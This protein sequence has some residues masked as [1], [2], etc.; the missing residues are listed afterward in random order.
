MSLTKNFLGAP[1]TNNAANALSMQEPVKL[2][3]PGQNPEKQTN[4]L[5]IIMMVVMMGVMLGMV[6][7]M[8]MS[9]GG[10]RNPM[11]L[12][13][14]IMMMMSMGMMMFS[15]GSGTSGELSTVRSD[16]VKELALARRDVHEAE[17]KLFRFQQA[18][19]PPPDMIIHYIGEE[20]P[21]E[22]DIIP[23]WSLTEEDPGGFDDKDGKFEYLDTSFVPYQAPR[24]G[25]S[26]VKAYPGF[27]MPEL[28]VQENNEPATTSTLRRF[29][30]THRSVAKVP[31]GISYSPDHLPSGGVGYT[32][33]QDILYEMM[34]Q[35]I[36]SLAYGH[37]P[38]I[39]RLAV[40]TTPERAP[41]WEWVKWLPHFQ[42]PLR[43]TKTG[44]GIMLYTNLPDYLE[45][46]K[47]LRGY[48]TEEGEAHTVVFVDMPHKEVSKPALPGRTHT[49]AVFA[50]G[51][52]YIATDKDNRYE[53]S[54]KGLMILPKSQSEMDVSRMSRAAAEF[55][56]MKMSQYTTLTRA[57]DEGVAVK[58]SSGAAH[59]KITWLDSLQITDM[60]SFDPRE[61]WQKNLYSSN[62][63]TPLGNKWD[64]ATNTYDES[65]LFTLDLGQRG[66]VNGDG[67][68]GNGGGDTG[69]GKSELL[70]VLVMG[71]MVNY[72]PHTAAFILMDFKGGS[73][74][75]GYDELP[76]VIANI[77]NLEGQSDMVD[78][79]YLVIDGLIQSRQEI[80][81]TYGAKDVIEYRKM[82]RQGKIPDSA[83]DL[84]DVFVIEDEYSEFLE[85]HPDFAQLFD[86]IGRVGR[87]LGIHEL[88]FTQDMNSQLLGTLG[89]QL[90][91]SIALKVNNAASRD[92]IGSGAATTDL[93]DPG[94][95]FIRIRSTEEVHRIKGFFSEAPYIPKEA[96]AE[97][98]VVIEDG[99]V[100]F[101]EKNVIEYRALERGVIDEEV[102]DVV[103][104]DETTAAEQSSDDLPNQHDVL[105]DRLRQFQDI[106]APKLWTTPLKVPF[107]YADSGVPASEVA[108]VLKVSIGEL[109]D[110]YHHRR[111]PHVVPLKG[112][113]HSMILVGAPESGKSM[114][115]NSIVSSLSLQYGPDVVQVIILD[116]TGKGVSRLVDSYPHVIASGN[117]AK[118]D[119][120][121]RFTG[122]LERIMAIRQARKADWDCS[123]MEEYFAEVKKRGL[124]NDDPYG[125]IVF[126]V[127]GMD[128]AMSNDI[129][130]TALSKQM[131]PKFLKWIQ[132]GE[133]VGVHLIFTTSNLNHK[134]SSLNIGILALAGA[135][136]EVSYSSAM[137]SGGVART[138]LKKAIQSIPKGQPGRYVDTSGLHGRFRF[139]VQDPFEPT[140]YDAKSGEPVFTYD[141]SHDARVTEL[142]A[143]VT[144]NSD[145]RRII[146]PLES[147]SKDMSY[148]YLMDRYWSHRHQGA[149]DID[150]P[151]GL[152]VSDLSFVT[153]PARE[154]LFVAGDKGVGKSSVLRTVMNAV[155]QQ[156]SSEPKERQP[157]FMI[158]DGSGDW[159]NE[160][161]VMEK[162]GRLAGYVSTP[163]E[164]KEMFDAIAH[165]MRAHMPDMETLTSEQ[166]ENRTWYS[167]RDI[168]VIIDGFQKFKG[169]YLSKPTDELEKALLECGRNDLGFQFFISD[170]TD[171]AISLFQGKNLVQSLTL[172]GLNTL[173][174]SSA[175]KQIVSEVRTRR[176]NAGRGTFKTSQGSQRIVQTAESKPY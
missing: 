131:A 158:A 49:Y 135:P 64:D 120:F 34:N 105:M 165:Q 174:L 26:L 129:E 111:I 173:V 110:P 103:A 90:G 19:F 41:E 79:A 92:L 70:K 74:F 132:D 170:S 126:C 127:D 57:G 5:K 150:I 80:F 118:E 61:R 93:S 65:T 141:T 53:V 144:E 55:A 29:V 8:F 163:M 123:T 151:L 154:N 73:T 27:V 89:K 168:I 169:D 139:P 128:N 50:A 52:D 78:R 21:P 106:Q 95:M 20:Q 71:L 157:M 39:L 171:D 147:V 35:Q 60:D 10:M 88:P 36:I 102:E 116:W 54:E 136:D 11:M 16:F 176:F 3:D 159:F 18:N 164:A 107:T 166:R 1:R 81:D 56:A 7:L 83:G 112:S 6:G 137:Q 148:D 82:R 91:F 38:D 44:P 100:K 51:V 86:R 98:T 167:D 68:H 66:G 130:E 43:M 59:R 63:K 104:E 76:H 96:S 153:V 72:S 24:I 94:E 138:E 12:M 33:D 113:T 87:S 109:D 161:K 124:T 142:G 77:S 175:P 47:A 67:P 108:D 149:K 28:Q 25:T 134:F 75:K 125:Q 155:Y 15:G 140:K 119:D 58:R 85:Q 115:L 145:P 114:A 133:A 30:R 172:S 152:S 32:G 13:M 69:Y 156:T 62:F 17:D 97:S 84:P 22:N 121:L 42:N 162:E 46:Q 37:S 23:M 9:G 48:T 99:E 4:L 122:E 146:A 160:M 45:D 117:A 101:D 40:L 14:P 143:L 2:P 31:T